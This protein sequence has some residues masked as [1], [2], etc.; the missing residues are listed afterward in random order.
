MFGNFENHTETLI[1]SGEN[2]LDAG[3]F[4]RSFAFLIDHLILLCFLVFLFDISVKDISALIYFAINMTNL[5]FGIL[6]IIIILF[7]EIYFAI[8]E[9]L[10]NGMT[11][12]KWLLGLKVVMDNGEKLGLLPSVIRN[13]LRCTYLFPLIFLFPDVICLIISQN[14]KRIGDYLAGTRVVRKKSLKTKEVQH[15]PGAENLPESKDN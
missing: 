11:P 6:I 1:H 5:K 9:W 13:L 3:F 7:F 10:W 14:N 12:G 8:F 15:F 4:R 2:F